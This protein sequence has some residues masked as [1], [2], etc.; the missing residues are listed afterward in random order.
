MN[1]AVEASTEVKLTVRM[2]TAIVCIV[3]LAGCA[4]Q[5]DAG[6]NARVAGETPSSGAGGQSSE[7]TSGD[8]ATTSP[9]TTAGKQ[10]TS[11]TIRVSGGLR[12]D[13]ERRVY[14]EGA[15]PPPGQTRAEVT[16]LLE[17]ASAP[18]LIDAELTKLPAQTCCDRQ[19]YVV[20]VQY[21][22]G[23]QRTYTSLDGLEQ[24]SVFEKF[25]GLL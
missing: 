5:D 14:S 7:P 9:D 17:A 6:P 25:L 18:E 16:E 10:A 20:T 15:P 4:R 11:V 22:D 1:K 24:P 23:S 12:G 2:T 3:A 19:T 21:D 13:T 8:T